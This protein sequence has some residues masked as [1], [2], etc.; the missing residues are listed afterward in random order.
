LKLDIIEFEILYK[1]LISMAEEMGVVLQKS[2]FSPNIRERLDA[3]CALF[4]GNRALLAQAEHI[5]V[6]LGSMHLP[7]E[8]IDLELSSG[9][10]VI[11]ND[12]A[13]GGTH[14]PDITIYKPIFYDDQLVSFV[15]NRA[16]HADIGG[17]TP[18]SMPG[19][20]TEIYQEGLIIPPVKI[21][22]GGKLGRDVMALV[23]SNVRT[24]DERRGDLMAQLGANNHGRNLLKEFL[25]TYG[26]DTYHD[27]G[28][29]IMDYTR[30]MLKTRLEK[31]AKGDFFAEDVL[32]LNNGEVKLQA[33][34]RIN[35]HVSID[36]NGTSS[37][38]RSNLNAPLAVTH[39]AVYF[40]FRTIL[41][42]DIPANSAFYEFFEINAPEGSIV[43]A[44]AGAPVVGGNVETSQRIVDVLLSALSE[45]FDAPAQSHGTMNNISFGNSEFTFY[46]T[47]GGGAGAAAGYNG[48]SGVHV[49]MTNTKNTPVEVTEASYP[50]LCMKYSLKPG[51]G[52]KGN[53]TGGDGIIK[54]YRALA[55]CMF[56]IISDR[57]KNPPRGRAGGGD[58]RPGKNIVVRN[59]SVEGIGGK[60]SILLNKNDEVIVET[61][62]GGGYGSIN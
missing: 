4:G 26:L 5:P 42:S 22:D 50:L 35:G 18:G 21:V 48:A 52:G 54:H 2:S 60:T 13:L 44:P 62:G 1:N 12:P 19:N 8:H 58:G 39:S 32:E 53:W 23:L 56:S 33:K 49:Y 30:Q 10:Q 15:A 45:A 24:P 34:I 47:L 36:F 27:L 37:E 6:H 31:I 29:D 14:L 9:D 59:G 38:P 41:G 61:P 25:D 16:H 57:R 20:S 7:L 51:S 11:L 28:S 40:F 3:S 55:S 46:E 43:N 17:M